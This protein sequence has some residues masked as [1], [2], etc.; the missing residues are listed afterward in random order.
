M[1]SVWRSAMRN[2]I[3]FVD[4]WWISGEWIFPFFSFI[5]DLIDFMGQLFLC[6]A[7]KRFPVHG[8]SQIV[9]DPGIVLRFIG[10]SIW[11][12]LI[13][14]NWGSSWCL[15]TDGTNLTSKSGWFNRNW[16]TRR[17]LSSIISR[18]DSWG[19]CMT[20]KIVSI[21]LQGLNCYKHPLH[22]K[23]KYQKSNFQ[24]FASLPPPHS[25]K[26]APKHIGL[27]SLA[28]CQMNYCFH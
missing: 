9:I 20:Q 16:K 27:V 15:I 11:G 2:E 28:V 21:L 24:L 1:V 3:W 22:Q 8:I 14:N 26:N 5:S 7:K 19:S 13:V 23:I 10:H 12:L 6:E 17:F 18:K 4:V 25:S